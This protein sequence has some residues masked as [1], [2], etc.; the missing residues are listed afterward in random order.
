M[1]VRFSCCGLERVEELNH[2]RRRT[3]RQHGLV[4]GTRKGRLRSD[5]VGQFLAFGDGIG[6]GV[7]L[8]DRA[9]MGIDLCLLMP[10]LNRGELGFHLCSNLFQQFGLQRFTQRCHALRVELLDACGNRLIGKVAKNGRVHSLLDGGC[11][12]RYCLV[13]LGRLLPFVGALLGLGFQTG[14]LLQRSGRLRLPVLLTLARFVQ[15]LVGDG[16]NTVLCQ[17]HSL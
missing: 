13:L 17:N 14:Q 1:L 6:V 7:L 5:P 9:H 3:L 16:V 2:F 15:L 12:G 10:L 4:T 8:V 11:S